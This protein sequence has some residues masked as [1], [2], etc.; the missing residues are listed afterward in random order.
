MQNFSDFFPDEL[1]EQ[2]ANNNLKVGA[3][4]RIPVSFTTPP[5]VKRLIIV[6]FDSQ[7][8]AL[9]SVLINSE[10]NP[11][12]FPTQRLKDLHLE[13][14]EN[15]RDYLDHTSYVDCSQIREMEVTSIK[16][17]LMDDPAICIGALDTTD[18][19]NV[20]DKI[21]TAHT[22]SNKVKKKFGFK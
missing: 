10:I 13:L 20:I 15:N 17:M 4:L 19:T 21:K 9:A 14:D 18:L 1:K 2:I 16:S 6:G 8:I 12:K 11:N 3:V 22:I 7:N 5:K